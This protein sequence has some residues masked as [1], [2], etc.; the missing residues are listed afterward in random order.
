MKVY[1]IENIP[2]LH[3]AEF[4]NITHRSI[5]ST[6]VLIERGN[7][8]RKLK[9][10]RD[11]SRLMIPVAELDGYPFTAQGSAVH[12]KEVFHYY[13]DGDNYYKKLCEQCSYGEMC[14]PRKVADE[15][16]VPKGDK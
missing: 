16:I 15:L 7:S 12:A 13:K 11:R 5:Q 8:I 1:T 4:A 10:F 6:R 9:A 2:M 14:E 3:I